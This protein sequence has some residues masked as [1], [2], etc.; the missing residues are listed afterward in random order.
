MTILWRAARTAAAGVILLA[1]VTEQ[2]WGWGAEGHRMINR[3]AAATLP[4]DVPAFLHDGGAL[5]TLE[6]LG[7]EPDRW[8]S[9]AEPE[10]TVEQEPDHF[11]DLEWADLV[12]PLPRRRYDFLRELERAQTAHPDLPLTPEKVGMQPWA[13]DEVWERLKA[14]MREYRQ[15]EA[16]N[17]DTRPVEIAIPV[18]RGLARPLRGGR[19]A[20]APRHPPVQRL[21]RSESARVHHRAQD[22]QPV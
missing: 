15:M 16:A 1:T 20:A 8:K 7:P 11:I 19:I 22:S 21:D 5:D 2:S 17:Q 18:L 6:Y 3:I 10:L 13:A 9:R 4:S 14:A 12:G